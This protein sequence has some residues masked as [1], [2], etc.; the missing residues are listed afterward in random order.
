MFCAWLRVLSLPRFDRPILPLVTAAKNCCDPA[1][2]EVDALQLAIASGG[3]RENPID[4][5][6]GLLLITVSIGASSNRT[7]TSDRSLDSE[8]DQALYLAK[9]R[10]KDR[11]ERFSDI[12]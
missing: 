11:V 1:W 7:T 5:P 10:G 2:T 3:G 8:A 4:T 6:R 9:R 12:A